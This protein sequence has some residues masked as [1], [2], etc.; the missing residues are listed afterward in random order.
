VQAI[1]I[2]ILGNP[3]DISVSGRDLLLLTSTFPI[4]PFSSPSCTMGFLGQPPG[5]E[6]QPNDGMEEPMH[7]DRV[8]VSWDALKSNWLVRIQAGEEAIRRHC[9]IPKDADEQTLHSVAKK[10]LQ[11]EGYDPDV[12]VIN[13]RR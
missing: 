2:G 6:S 3:V 1:E 4:G 7:A 5:V 10:T 9:K 13:I 11:E 8:E 12:A